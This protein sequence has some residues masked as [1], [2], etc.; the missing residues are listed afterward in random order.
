MALP[1]AAAA[2]QARDAL[3]ATGYDAPKWASFL[4]TSDAPPARGCAFE[5]NPLRRWQRQAARACDESAR[6]RRIFLTS[7]AAAVAGWATL[8]PSHHRR[9]HARSRVLSECAVPRSAPAAPAPAPATRPDAFGDHRAVRATSGVLAAR[10]GPPK[11]A[12]AW[13]CREAGAR[14]A[15]NVRVADMNIDVPVADDRRIEVMGSRGQR[16]VPLA[17]HA[18]RG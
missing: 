13:V 3:R 7:R 6:A 11:R 17:R 8:C 4:D 2:N 1:A 12:V 10:A 16:L 14:V 15:R 9:A 5:P 18:A